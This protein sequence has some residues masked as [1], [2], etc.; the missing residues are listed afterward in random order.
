MLSS[1][2]TFPIIRLEDDKHN[3]GD[4]NGDDNDDEKDDDDEKR[5]T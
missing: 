4:V 2:F 3:D 1:S 5:Q